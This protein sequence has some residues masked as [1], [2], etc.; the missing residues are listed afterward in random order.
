[1][2]RSA[3]QSKTEEAVVPLCTVILVVKEASSS[4][5]VPQTRLEPC[6]GSEGVSAGVR[7]AQEATA[8]TSWLLSAGASEKGVENSEGGPGHACAESRRRAS[9]AGLI[10]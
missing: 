4:V 6:S 10:S 3:T 2:S 8:S 7:A 9:G 5:I 1:M